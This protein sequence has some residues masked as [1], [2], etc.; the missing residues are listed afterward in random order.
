MLLNRFSKYSCSRFLEAVYDNDIRMTRHG[1]TSKLMVP[2]FN[3]KFGERSFS[4]VSPKIYNRMP[5]TITSAESLVSFKAFL[6][7]FKLCMNLK[8][9]IND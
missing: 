9:F 7:V 2:S 3:S 4:G 6:K 1:H 5:T 8:N